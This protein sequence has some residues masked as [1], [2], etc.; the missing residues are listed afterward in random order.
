M[1]TSLDVDSSV[2]ATEPEHHEED[3]EREQ[4]LSTYLMNPNTTPEYTATKLVI[5]YVMEPTPKESSK[6][7]VTKFTEPHLQLSCSTWMHHTT[8][9]I[10]AILLLNMHQSFTSFLANIQPSTNASYKGRP[11]VK[12]MPGLLHHGEEINRSGTQRV[13]TNTISQ[14][15]G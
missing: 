8:P 4:V 6:K 9:C 10:S 5:E 1:D 12:I 3:Y 15:H 11:E 13:A 2:F 14:P 7:D